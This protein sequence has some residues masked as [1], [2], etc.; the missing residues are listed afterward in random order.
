MNSVAKRAVRAAITSAGIAYEGFR[1]LRSLIYWRL[2]WAIRVVFGSAVDERRFKRRDRAFVRSSFTNVNLP[3]RAWLADR[4][5]ADVH[6]QDVLEVGCGWGANLEVL[7]HRFKSLRVTGVDISPESIAEG[8]IRLASNGLDQ[9]RLL[10]ATADDLTAFGDGAFD[11]VFTDAVLLYVGPDKI[12]RSIREMLRVTRCQLVMLE[13]HQIGFGALGR[14]TRDGWVRD[15]ASLMQRVLPGETVEV[16]PLPP[17]A[18]PA[19]RWPQRGALVK[20]SLPE[21]ARK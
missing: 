1:K 7:A 19:G 9:V 21:A 13:L 17:E 6:I 15:Y 10:R 20:V 8:A 3:H 4:L 2:Q 16:T 18:R 12:E 14:Y 11:V 5:M